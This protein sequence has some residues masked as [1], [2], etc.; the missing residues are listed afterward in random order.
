MSDFSAFRAHCFAAARAVGGRL[1]SIEAPLQRVDANFARA[2]LELPTGAIA[3]LLNAHYPLVAFAEPTT[4]GDTRLRFIDAP[5]VREAFVNFGIYE[6]LP[7]E[8]LEQRIADE[9]CCILSEAEQEQIRFW[10]P[11]RAGELVFNCW[12]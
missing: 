2:I 6:V 7:A 10:R 11:K 5:A 9:S 3:V 1:R 4:E 12:D 8:E